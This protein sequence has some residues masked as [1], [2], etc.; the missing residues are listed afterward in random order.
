MAGP[1]RRGNSAVLAT[2]FAIGGLVAIPT[3]AR[4]ATP[5]R[6]IPA[7]LH[8]TIT[9]TAI[10]PSAFTLA[11]GQTAQFVN[12]SGATQTITADDG[13]F[14]SGPIA[15]G[16]A[17]GLA[18]GE[19]GSWAIHSANNAQLVGDVT[20]GI[21]DL[22]G[23]PSATLPGALSKMLIPPVDD[24]DAHPMGIY[25]STSRAVVG[26][27]PGATVDQ[28]NDALGQAGVTVIGTIPALNAAV[29]QV[30]PEPSPGDFA[31]LTTAIAA[32][33]AHPAIAAVTLDKLTDGAV[34]PPT[35]DASAPSGWSWDDARPPGGSAPPVGTGSNWHLESARF[36]NAWNVIDKVR[37]ANP[38]VDTAVFDAAFPSNPDLVEPIVSLCS[39]IRWNCNSQ[40]AGDHGT[41]VSGAIGAGWD[42]AGAA[43]NTSFGISG[44]NPASAGHLF[45]VPY[46]GRNL[47]RPQVPVTTS[48]ARGSDTSA[49]YGLWAEM[50]EQ[51]RPGGAFPDLRV[52][53]M[54]STTVV[55]LLNAAGQ[56]AWGQDHAGKRCGPG[57][58]DDAGSTGPCTPNT[59]DTFLQ[60]TAADGVF[61][62]EVAE[63][64]A[65]K[66]VLL[67]IATGNDGQKVCESAT[68][69]ASPSTANPPVCPAGLTFTAMDARK[70]HAFGWADVN[71]SSGANPILMVDAV[72]INNKYGSFSDVGGDVSAPGVNVTST[73]QGSPAFKAAS[74]TSIAAPIVAALA[75][76]LIAEKPD[77]TVQQVRDLIIRGA[78]A[79]TTRSNP[80]AN[81]SPRIDAYASLLLV[82]GAAH[83]LAD[84][85][86]PSV[87]G[88]RRLVR[89]RNGST[90]VDDV[91]GPTVPAGLT[92][93]APDGKVDMR[94]FRRFRDAL[95]EA[96]QRR[97]VGTAGCVSDRSSINLDG[98]PNHS[99]KD[100]N[101]DRCTLTTIAACAADEEVFSRFDLNGDGVLL[102]NQSAP[103]PLGAGG[104]TVQKTDF[105]MFQDQFDDG[106]PGAEGRTRADLPGLLTSG[107]LEIHADTMFFAGAPKVDVE[108][109]YG[110]LSA[111]SP[112]RSIDKRGDTIVVTTPAPPGDNTYQVI[113]HATV[114]G[115]QIDS[116]LETGELAP[117]EDRRVDLCVPTLALTTPTGS[118][119]ADGATKA[120]VRASLIACG[121]DVVPLD[122]RDVEFTVEQRDLP[123]PPKATLSA[124]SATTNKNGK[125]AVQLNVSDRPEHLHLIATATIDDKPVTGT[126]DF[127]ITNPPRVIYRWEQTTTSWT[128]HTHA[129][130]DGGGFGPGTDTDSDLVG[131]TPATIS[132]TGSLTPIGDS[133]ARLVE[134]APANP[135]S[136][137][138]TATEHV[139]GQTSS[140]DLTEVIPV[141]QRHQDITLSTYPVKIYQANGDQLP[142]DQATL[143]KTSFTT[144]DDQLTVHHFADVGGVAYRMSGLP[145]SSCT[146]S[147]F[148][149]DESEL[150]QVALNERKFGSA[151]EFAPDLTKDLTFTK[152]PNGSWSSYVYCGP[153]KTL[154]MRGYQGILS[155]KHTAT[156]SATSSA[157]FVATVVTDDTDPATLEFGD[158][159]NPK[160]PISS[161]SRFPIEPNEGQTV[162]FVDASSDPNGDVVS[163][164]WDFGDG[165]TSTQQYPDHVFADDGSYTVSLKVT[166]AT[167]ESD[168]SLADVTVKNVTPVVSAEDVTVDSGEAAEVPVS[169]TDPGSRDAEALTVTVTSTDKDV[170]VYPPVVVAAGNESLN[171][172]FLPDGSHPMTITVADKDGASSTAQFT[173]TV[174][175]ADPPAVVDPDGEIET[176]PA[177]R[178]AF[179]VK[180]D[181]GESDLVDQITQ[182]R[183]YNSLSSLYASPTLTAA[184]EEQVAYLRDNDL[185]SHTGANGTTPAQRA[186][187]AT[188]PGLHVGE[189]LARGT[190]TANGALVAWKSSPDHDAN[191]LDPVWNAIGVAKVT[192]THGTLWATVFG[193][194]N[195]C[196][197][198]PPDLGPSGEPDP[199]IVANPPNPPVEVL[200]WSDAAPAAPAAAAASESGVPVSAFTVTNVAPSTGAPITITNR[201]SATVPLSLGDGR[202]LA[203]LAPGASITTNYVSPG[204]A[205]AQIGDASLNAL[206][207]IAVGGAALPP[208]VS[209][210]GPT[211][212]AQESTV[213]LSALVRTTAL[214]PVAGR[215]VD[216]AV[217]GKVAHGVTD[218]AGHTSASLKLDVA[219]G[220]YSLVISVPALP[221][222]G[223]DAT[224]AVPFTVSP[225]APPVATAGGPYTVLFNDALPLD[226]TG[227]F[228][229]EAGSISV[230]W[231]LNNDGAFDDAQ[232]LQPTVAADQTNQ[233]V[234]GGSCTPGTANP[235]KVRVTDSK[236][237]E[238]IASSTVTFTRDFGLQI[239][240]GAVTIN[241]GGSVSMQVS[242]VTTSDFTG[243]VAL[244]APNLPVGVTAQFSPP[245]VTPNGTSLLTVTAAA[246]AQQVTAPLV[247]RGVSGSIV[248][249]ANGTVDVEFG[250]VPQC[251]TALDIHVVDG[252]T[253]APLPGVNVSF[254]NAPPTDTNGDSR[255]DHI[256]LGPGNAPGEVFISLGRTGYFPVAVGNVLVGCGVIGTL[257]TAY[258]TDAPRIT[259]RQ[260]PGG[261]ARPER[262][263]LQP[264][265]HGDEHAD[266]RR[267][268]QPQRRPHR[269]RQR[270][271]R[272]QRHQP[273]RQQRARDAL[274]DLLGQRVRPR[275]DRRDGGG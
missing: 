8:V 148:C 226:A 215:G 128:A 52:I 230:A 164:E 208:T 30:V 131:S 258:D 239:T 65:A 256:P 1:L 218:A 183:K 51:K 20:V 49:N 6:P 56:V 151:I 269:R 224:T 200:G 237:A 174:G 36:P 70:Q 209:N 97:P 189:N 26:F 143:G 145:D 122:G 76:W 10:E 83:D 11:V 94:D 29:V 58:N 82:P 5:A 13:A 165:T 212:G 48:F 194:V 178:C 154:D 91:K 162:N 150:D 92:Y 63:K 125:A 184:A 100:L 53:N 118:A 108:V 228:D 199:V 204:T 261:R 99:K 167:G 185:F 147:Q 67:T 77:L 74:G 132:R 104:A 72:D 217:A 243:S 28:A 254:G 192:T 78:R 191:V 234:C 257:D 15:A 225:N 271:V 274:G 25:A 129:H 115:K 149:F 46:G 186:F 80:A 126:T 102:A 233:V 50:L 195:D 264:Q 55:F 155:G 93:S 275:A 136:Y 64:A 196:P 260:R 33:R 270:S 43:A 2:L 170:P 75:G 251:F 203:T 249:D 90:T 42:N 180:L 21:L 169:L 250:L 158:C 181:T 240:P 89:S 161:I 88:N 106:T 133:D 41:F 32:L 60:D 18:L 134:D 214:V 182:Y 123:D 111:A 267:E 153:T 44:G 107:D 61:A 187:A 113:G 103:V 57:S 152:L 242:V 171:L 139:S 210:D 216:F 245:A 259:Q 66:D 252:E 87:D 98:F 222:P 95:L 238:T 38:S 79:D 27:N 31:P 157:R 159:T 86:D 253:N 120:D 34:T 262:P 68:A 17:F 7:P 235:I 37:S 24:M 127:D 69:T 71:W 244:T 101:N 268:H 173:V 47:S 211:A 188:Y 263:H 119:F 14:D 160:P 121:E 114:G 248:H 130:D 135:I 84:L 206:L 16:G 168:T 9:P 109:R 207:D 116:I 272:D 265:G 54:S 105:Q 201:S 220:A 73:V 12:G 146:G 246:N 197:D 273:E 156:G 175:D 144:N 138:F 176:E 137:H 163:W 35:P 266:S 236:G 23:A 198:G 241:P 40:L 221:G 229:P 59:D 39:L 231:D 177:P 19:A 205:I 223:V 96:C 142:V 193:D 81:P 22:P 219:A 213:T 4:A 166:D 3:T 110:S 140:G 255:Y 190:T 45:A 179:G 112:A 62:R 247:V 202:P 124:P 85:S 172:G 227:S 141:G 117:G 232:G